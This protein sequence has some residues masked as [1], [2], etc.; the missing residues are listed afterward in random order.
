[1]FSTVKYCHHRDQL[2]TKL[3]NHD[4]TSLDPTFTLWKAV[5]SANGVQKTSI[6][7]ACTSC[8]KPFLESLETGMIGSDA[9]RRRQS[10]HRDIDD[11]YNSYKLS[12][13]TTEPTPT[14]LFANRGQIGDSLGTRTTVCAMNGSIRIYDETAIRQATTP[15]TI[16]PLEHGQSMLGK[17]WVIDLKGTR[18]DAGLC[19]F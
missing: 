9:I 10:R 12:N 4:V 6:I 19:R 14:Y 2:S 3:S 13:I 11:V 18:R 16:K 5:L 15:P 17:A 7:T 1:M 8:L